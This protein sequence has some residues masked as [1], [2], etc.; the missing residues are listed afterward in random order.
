MP[1][2]EDWSPTQLFIF[3]VCRTT[4]STSRTSDPNHQSIHDGRTKKRKTTSKICQKQQNQ[5]NTH[6]HT[7]KTGHV[8]FSHYSIQMLSSSEQ[9]TGLFQHFH[10]LFF[11]FNILLLV[12]FGYLS[13]QGTRKHTCTDTHWNNTH[14]HTQ[15]QFHNKDRDCAMLLQRG[16]C[17]VG[18]AQGATAISCQ[19]FTHKHAHTRTH[20]QFIP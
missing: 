1:H 14:S 5:Y 3:R 16:Q 18:K 12:L 8:V 10:F 20:R 17:H 4:Y 19:H 15:S 2:S 7:H 6:T 13:F 11:Y 9:T